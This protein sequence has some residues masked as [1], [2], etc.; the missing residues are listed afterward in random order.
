MLLFKYVKLNGQLVVC[1]KQK[2][3]Q[4]INFVMFL[5]FDSGDQGHSNKKINR[6]VLVSFNEIL[7]INNENRSSITMKLFNKEFLDRKLIFL[8]KENL[9][10]QKKKCKLVA[11]VKCLLLHSMKICFKHVTQDNDLI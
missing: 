9:N 10:Y 1:N 6:N 8:N 5:P 11:H 3:L 2:T 4:V 7:R